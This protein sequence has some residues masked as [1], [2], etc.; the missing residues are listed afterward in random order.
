MEKETLGWIL[1]TIYFILGL[2][3]L[4]VLKNGELNSVG[5]ILFLLLLFT[6]FALMC[7]E[8]YKLYRESNNSPKEK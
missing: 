4:Y 7:Y 1:I 3:D 8:G 6:F 5:I 2:L